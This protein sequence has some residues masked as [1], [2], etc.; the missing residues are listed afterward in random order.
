MSD[1]KEAKFISEL[2]KKMTKLRRE[3]L[4]VEKGLI[5]I[6]IEVIERNEELKKID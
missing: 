3:M 6:I 2:F 4:K 1:K 5:E